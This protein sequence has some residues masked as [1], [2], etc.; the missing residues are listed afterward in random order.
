MRVETS[1]L[2]VIDLLPADDVTDD[3]ESPAPTP[4]AYIREHRK[5]S[6][7]SLEQ[8]A[9]ATKIP[10]RQIEAIEHDR[11]GELPG[12][13]FVKGF[14]R[15]CA[16]AMKLDEETVIGL[17]YEQERAALQT[18]RRESPSPPRPS[19]TS[20]RASSLPA[21][22]VP[23]LPSPRVLMWSAVL[24]ILTLFVLVAFT[25]VAHM[26]GGQSIS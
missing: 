11:F 9:A 25:L 22:V 12:L 23:L 3:C 15:C 18:R 13:V 4:G 7:L 19:T 21:R 6:G 1:R 14:L 8:L 16:R 17:Y 5:R 10:K 24:V 2:R 26:G 20:S